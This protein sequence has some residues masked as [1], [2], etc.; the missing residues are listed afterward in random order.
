MYDNA[1]KVTSTK[2]QESLKMYDS[3]KGG[4]GEL[5]K[6]NKNVEKPDEIKNKSLMGV[7]DKEKE[8]G[9]T[10]DKLGKYRISWNSKLEY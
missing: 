2:S 5:V 8:K 10:I 1:Y 6:I 9:E 7:N 4:L 3:K